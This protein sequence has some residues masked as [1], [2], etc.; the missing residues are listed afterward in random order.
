[1][2]K[3]KPGTYPVKQEMVCNDQGCVLKTTIVTGRHR[4]TVI[5][6]SPVQ[7][8]G[9]SAE[10]QQEQST[11]ERHRTTCID[12]LELKVVGPF[13]TVD[14]TTLPAFIQT[15]DTMNTMDWN[16]YFKGGSFDRA[17]LY[18]DFVKLRN[19]RS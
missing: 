14:D 1:M 13:E 3:I 4:G 19:A 5:D 7:T 18:E 9:L 15:M 6:T 16:H 12:Y 11:L 17:L 2:A 10:E 8:P